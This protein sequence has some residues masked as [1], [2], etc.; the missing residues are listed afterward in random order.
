MSSLG[1]VIAGPFIY[2]AMGVF[3]CATA[4]K[5]IAILRMPRPL[6][7]DL[8]P[9]P[10]RGEAGSKYQHLDFSTHKAKFFLLPEIWEMATEILFIKRLLKNNP[11]LW[12]GSFAMHAGI[13]LSV[14]WIV[15]LLAGAIVRIVAPD[16]NSGIIT[17]LFLLS[18]VTG[19]A[20][21]VLGL[22]GSIYLLL[23]RYL[24]P[25]LRTM[26]DMVTFLNLALMIALFASAL[27]AWLAADG[28]FDLLRSQIAGLITF[29]PAAPNHP[30]ITVELF[31]FGLFLM[32]LPF[33]RM[34]HFAAKYFFYHNIMWDDEAMSHGSGLE[35]ER[36]KELAF[37]LDW[38]GPH[39]KTNQSWLEQ[40]SDRRTQKEQESK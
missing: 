26:S 30:L 17:G 9:L 18:T 4:C 40:V 22:A 1:W 11:R 19:G 32:Y 33:S 10:H 3:V 8:Y 14:L 38:A 6:R 39:I 13:Y 23:R 29:K 7:W 34:L 5:I 25:D 16:L 21:L 2:L 37:H 12:V 15:L 24:E 27:V 36:V 20:A 35:Q 31:F 28:S